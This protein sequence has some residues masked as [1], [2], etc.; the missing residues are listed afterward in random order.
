MEKQTGVIIKQNT[1]KLWLFCML[2]GL[3]WGVVMSVIM[4]IIFLPF[5]LFIPLITMP[6][7]AIAGVVMCLFFI[8]ALKPIEKHF[9]AKREEISATKT[10]IVDGAANLD[11]AGGWL[12]FTED[13]VE[14]H[15]HK[16]NFDTSSVI[17]PRA[18]VQNI[19]KKKND[20]IITANGTD[21][22]FVVNYGNR[23]VEILASSWPVTA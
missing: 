3:A 7:G 13:T 15:A 22:K 1:G 19:Q 12:F 6:L 17:I 8:G 11:K 14:F 2:A 10:I 21:Y 23:W 18:E 5:A 9:T 4:G 20:L 16:A